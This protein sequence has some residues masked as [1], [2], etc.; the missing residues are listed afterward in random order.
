M[1]Q[2]EVRSPDPEFFGFH[3]SAVAFGGVIRSSNTDAGRPVYA[4]SV[5]LAPVGGK[6]GDDVPEFS[7]EG[8]SFINGKTTVSGVR[9]ENKF[10]TTTTVSLD[11][12]DIYGTVKV[13]HM[14]AVIQSVRDLDDRKV[15]EPKFSFEAAIEGLVIDGTKYEKAPLDLKF[16]SEEVPTYAD[17]LQYFKRSLPRKVREKKFDRFGWTSDENR[18][19]GERILKALNDVADGLRPPLEAVRATLLGNPSRPGRS[20]Y[21][22]KGYT[23]HLPNG[24]GKIHLAEVVMKPG[25]RTLNL[26]RIELK[27][28]AI[29]SPRPGGREGVRAM[30]ASRE[31]FQT[32][33]ATSGT[34]STNG[35]NSYPP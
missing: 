33:Y 18:D 17:F 7:E 10:T 2:N 23:I 12:L 1:P 21:P 28:P 30:A 9:N 8:I 20:K 15:N 29:V 34:G 14:H 32:L 11:D 35:T 26:L 24:R 25:L 27:K 6:D 5:A 31:A 3:A 19:S 4:G 16:F 13:G 22:Q